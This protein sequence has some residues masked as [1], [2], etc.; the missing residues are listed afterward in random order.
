MADQGRVPPPHDGVAHHKLKTPPEPAPYRW[1]KGDRFRKG[2]HVWYVLGVHEDR[3]ILQS[4][5]TEWARTRPLT[6]EEWDEAGRSGF[7]L[8]RQG[9]ADVPRG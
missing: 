9:G 2:D 1:R 7:T 3:A 8:I 5:S 4:E 6:F